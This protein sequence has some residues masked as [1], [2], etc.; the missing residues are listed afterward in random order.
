MRFNPE[1]WKKLAESDFVSAW[2][3]SREILREENVNRRY[4]RK[5]IRVG[6]EHP[7][8]ETIQRLREA[9]L[10]MGFSEVVNPVFIEEIDVRR[11]FGK[12]ADAVLDR[13]FYLAG[14]PRPDVGM[15]EEKRREIERILGRKVADEEI[16]NLRRK[17]HEYKKGEFSG[18]DLAYEIGRALN[19]SDEIG[20]RI[21]DEVFPEFREMIPEATRTTL[22][23]HMTSGWFLTLQS[24]WWKMELPVK[25][26]SI[27]R[28]F[29]REQSEDA[30]RLMSYFSA[31]CVLMDEEVN[32][33]DGKAVAEALLSQFGF[34]DF[35]F[36]EDE[37]R[38]KY[39]I[40]GTQTEVFAYH[41][42]L[43]GSSTKYS[44]GWVEIATFGIYS[45]TALSHYEIPYPVM[46]LGLG[47][48]RLAMILY[49]YS[50]VREL[51]YPQFYGEWKMSDREIAC[52]LKLKLTPMSREG[53]EIAS[54]IYQGFLK[55]R[56]EMGPCEFEVWRGELFEREVK[57][58]ILESENVKLAGPAAFNE[59]LVVDGSIIAVPRTSKYEE[60]F[61][62][63]VSTGIVFAEAFANEASAIFEKA[64]LRGE[65][66]THRVR[67][68]R[69]PGDINV[70]VP[71]HVQRYITGRKKKIDVR[72]PAFLSSKVEILG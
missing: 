47:V 34:E 13:C 52:S 67:V 70:E 18:D 7:L 29:R 68:V 16:E 2:L 23:S 63:G 60:Y 53:E 51:V 9:Y 38:S 65:S 49:G 3:K 64:A 42:E 62:K 37:K 56:D 28:C 41:P 54:S 27:D 61:R 72:G 43:E 30:T 25:L 59:I 12:E 6:K 5:R 20:M 35:K 32:V 15:S 33:D 45:P 26:F 21:I 8:F 57:V 4:P 55:Y 58:S 69:S 46:N 44:D 66:L 71:Q 39:Y 31:S 17:L 24:L 36:R 50:D 10:R 19:E 11:Q 22:R 48:E 40:P 1:E 14:L